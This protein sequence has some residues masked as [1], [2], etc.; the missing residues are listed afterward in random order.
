MFIE[1]EAAGV[2]EDLE[3]ERCLPGAVVGKAIPSGMTEFVINV[4]WE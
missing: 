1:M 2:A 3:N 4:K